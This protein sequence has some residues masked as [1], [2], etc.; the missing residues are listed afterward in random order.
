MARRPSGRAKKIQQL[1]WEGFA[2]GALALAAGTAGVNV[3]S[4]ANNPYTLMRTRGQ[5]VA[6]IDGTEAPAVAVDVAV[7]MV[8][9]PEGQSATVLWDPLNDTNAPWFY[10]SRFTLGYEEYV[11]DVID[12]VGLPVYRE[13]IDVKA[14]RRVRSDE[15]IQLVIGNSTLSGAA[16]I[17]LRLGGR[18][19]QGE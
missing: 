11:T 9:M 12:A 15:E 13:T 1:K 10:Y 5:L 19:L 17:N 18:M 16:S 7:G 4:A 14:M 6:W 3:I 8:V 2:G